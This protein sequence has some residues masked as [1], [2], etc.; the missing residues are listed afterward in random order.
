MK[1]VLLVLAVS[2]VLSACSSL[3]AKIDD[4]YLNGK[5]TDDVRRIED[6]EL[7]IIDINEENKSLKNAVRITELNISI[8]GKEMEIQ[9][10]KKA[11]LKEKQRLF[12][13]TRNIRKQEETNKELEKNDER[14]KSETLNLN[15]YT[16]KLNDQKS[17]IELK[18]AELAVKV[19]ERLLEEAK[20]GRAAQNA[21]GT[22]EKE[23]DRIDIAEYEAYYNRKMAVFI[24]AQRNREGT[25]AAFKQSDDT[26]AES[27]FVRETE[28]DIR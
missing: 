5:S 21:R 17:H 26:L 10:M 13:V 16:A 6:I 4:E 8:V 23:T 2:M 14:M 7:G 22:P 3:P 19:A 12:T 18:D 1:N 20:I 24:E 15:W 28:G 27:R 11:L 25:L 9:K